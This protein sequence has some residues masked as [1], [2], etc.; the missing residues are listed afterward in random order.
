MD[1]PRVYTALFGV[2]VPGLIGLG[3]AGIAL[4]VH[5]VAKRR[6]EPDSTRTPRT[7]YG[8]ALGLGLAFSVVTVAF[9][10]MPA[11]WPVSASDWFAPIVLLSAIA[12]GAVDLARSPKRRA[13]IAWLGRAVVLGAV[14]FGPV[15]RPRINYWQGTDEI[16][17]HA[18]IGLWLV[19]AWLCVD[20]LS[21]RL[22]PLGSVTAAL[23]LV[24]G[25]IPVI[26]GAGVTGQSQYAGGLAAAIGGA[27]LIAIVSKGRVSIRAAGS[28]LVAW[29]AMAL[30][31][32]YQFVSEM[33]WWEFG[34]IAA[35]P[36]VLAG[37]TLL[38]GLQKLSPTKQGW[39][40]LVLVSVMTAAVSWQHVPDLYAELTG[41]RSASDA[42]WDY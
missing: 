3:C 14:L 27:G 40:V 13:I 42:Y 21:G 30:L 35:I 19:L 29:L 1:D 22:R 37:V 39:I 34:V 33:A 24:G 36:P 10:G 25:L 26:F 4:L 7:G 41:S 17:W 5:V 38:P 6:A 2:I 8:P 9:A 20:R 28:V 32:S 11:R 15:A 12:A 31:V 18:G 16:L 23:V